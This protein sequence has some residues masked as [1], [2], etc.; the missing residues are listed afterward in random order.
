[1]ADSVLVL[2]C[3]GFIGSH[4]V[5]EL[6]SRGYLVNET[7]P[8][9]ITNDPRKYSAIINCMGWNGGIEFN[10]KYPAKIFYENTVPTMMFLYELH[11]WNYKGRV[12]N[13]IASCAFNGEWGIIPPQP[14]ILDGRPHPSVD[15]HGYAKRNVYLMSQY[16]AGEMDIKLCCPGTVF[17]PRD[18]TDPARTKVLMGLVKKFVDAKEAGDEYVTVWGTGTPVREFLYVKT[19]AKKLADMIDGEGPFMTMVPG[20]RLSIRQLA[21]EIGWATGFS[22]KIRYDHTKPDGQMNKYFERSTTEV[23]PEFRQ[24]LKDTIEWYKSVKDRTSEETRNRN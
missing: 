16:L 1:M 10:R 8:P 7:N 5:E 20:T 9:N 3:N 19:L 2:G 4:V 18:K 24:G 15:C 6:T 17:G 21:R 12:I 22:G 13:M 14:D 23:T 11:K